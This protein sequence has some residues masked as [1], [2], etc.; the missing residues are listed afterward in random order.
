MIVTTTFDVPGRP[1]RKLLG[2]ARG[3]T[4]RSRH[5]GRTLL[6][7]FKAMFGGEIPDMTKVLAEAREQAFDRM[8]ED[9]RRMGANAVLGMRFTS[10]EVMGAAAEI[11]VYGT[12]A[13]VEEQP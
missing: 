5:F 10:A 1:T 2:I 13:V 9:A 4:I 11:V 7:E 12:A 6:A 8:V 3:S